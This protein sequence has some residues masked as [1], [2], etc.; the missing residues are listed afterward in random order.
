MKRFRKTLAA[1]IALATVI[2]LF[3]ITGCAKETTSTTAAL[4]RA[5][6]SATTEAGTTK[7]TTES[8]SDSESSSVSDTESSD[9]SS[10]TTPSD[11]T[12]EDTTSAETTPAKETQPLP[13]PVFTRLSDAPL[14]EFVPG[15]DYGEL[16][17]YVGNPQV[18]KTNLS[19]LGFFDANG[20][21]VCDPIFHSISRIKEDGFIVTHYE[22]DSTYTP[23]K[24]GFI[25]HDG[26]SF[27]G[28][29][30]DD[31]KFVEGKL[32]FYKIKDNS[33]TDYTFDTKKSV[34]TKELALKTFPPKDVGI[35]FGDIVE[36]R[37]L[38][39][40][41]DYGFDQYVVDG[42]SGKEVVYSDSDGLYYKELAG[43]LWIMGTSDQ[44]N[45][46]DSNLT[47]YKINGELL[48]KKD[49]FSSYQ[50]DAYTT[51][52]QVLFQQGN[53]WVILDKD[54]KTIHSLTSD[55]SHPILSFNQEENFFFARYED[56]IECYRKDF[57]NVFK[58]D[59][60]NPAEYSMILSDYS[61]PPQDM[62]TLD[63]ILYQKTETEITFLNMATK[64]SKTYSISDLPGNPVRLP[65]RILMLD[66]NYGSTPSTFSVL[67][68]SDFQIISAGSGMTTTILDSATGEC[69]L[70]VR[71]SYQHGKGSIIDATSGETV[72]K[73][74]INPE[75]TNLILEIQNGMFCY[76]AV[77]A[78]FDEDAAKQHPF[79]VLTDK[80]GK[81]FFLNYAEN[82][83]AK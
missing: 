80:D 67:S 83:Y 4:T 44:G 78:V 37:Y 61:V 11:T 56:A 47:V 25:S 65:G 24:C 71:E 48:Y 13:E 18:P 41:D 82:G 70:L 32:H 79:T 10:E 14:T 17:G 68:D 12:P 23:R 63:P 6:T 81:I 29:I 9:A 59:L 5:T 60:S 51:K 7:A 26:S 76:E 42:K 34:T 54:G 53:D 58:A 31:Y 22:G 20:R 66:E 15:S 40:E 74:V 62:A 75:Q 27:T 1:C 46:P 50:Y 64:K 19:L 77:P 2:S 43:N 28:L 55:P 52:D 8:A 30:Y 39:Y 16:Y 33:L 38:V 3:T 45:D 49:T 21:I 57:K 69:Y 35:Y 36:D 73:E 72:I